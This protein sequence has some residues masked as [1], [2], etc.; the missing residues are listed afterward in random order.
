MIFHW[1]RLALYFIGRLIIPPP[2][3]EDPQIDPDEKCPA[4]GARSNQIK[5]VIVTSKK[6]KAGE[7]AFREGRIQLDCRICGATRW[8]KPLYENLPGKGV[9]PIGADEVG[10]QVEVV[11]I[12]K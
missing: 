4:C 8:K 12:T 7:A 3:I 6:G 11:G 9:R 2:R 1:L 10:S 5:Y